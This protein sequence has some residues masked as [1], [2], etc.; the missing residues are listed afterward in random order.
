MSD[1][2]TEPAFSGS[3][4]ANQ[5][6]PR[7]GNGTRPLTAFEEK[8]LRFTKLRQKVF[9]EI[10][11]TYASIGAY[12]ILA[13][14]PTRAR[15][16]A[17]ISVYRAID[18]LLEAGVIHRLE[19]KNAF[20][21]CRR[22]DQ[23]HG[24]PADLPRRARNAAPWARSTARVSSILID[25]AARSANFTPRVKFVEVSGICP[26]CAPQENKAPHARAA[27]RDVSDAPRACRAASSSTTMRAAATRITGAPFD[28]D[29]RWSARAACASTA[30]AAHILIDIDIDIAS[31]RDRD[32]D[33]P[34]RRR[35]DDAGARAARASAARPRRR[36]RRR[37]I[38]AS[39][40]CRSA[41]T[42]TA[43]IPMT[44]ERFLAL[45]NGDGSA[46]AHRRRARRGRRRARARRQQLSELSG[47]ELQ[48]VVLARALLRDP[49]LL[50]LDEPVHGV[51]YM[52]EAELYTL[53]GRLRDRRGLGVLLVSHDL[54]IVMAASDRVI[55][56]NQP[57]L[58]LGRA[59][60][61]GAASR[62]HAPV[63][64]G[65]GARVRASIITITITATISPASRP[66]AAADG[67]HRHGD[68]R[69]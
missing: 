66:A 68:S 56:L 2:T 31:A 59:G 60:D 43:R 1:D 18:A 11:A 64:A 62:V 5:P 19:S 26:R 10:A 44:V 46:A 38:S 40:T 45:G 42:S 25:E 3:R 34:Q 7:Q 30:T 39:A 61:G 12:D 36:S 23:S 58:L 48:R 69:A 16:L 41:S 53:I 21:A 8:S 33:R 22:L 37:R 67:R 13:R 52:G 9:E 28:A 14:W 4:S 15:A 51:D 32:A 57:R 65:G 55:C 29:A 47:G 35:Q 20:F 24:P 27:G 49:D 54:H 63:R 50:V 6:P 17:P